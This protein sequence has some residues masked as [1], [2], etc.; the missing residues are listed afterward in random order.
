MVMK[1]FFE[2]QTI[3]FSSAT[4]METE[5]VELSEALGRILAGTVLA[6]ADMP[7]FNRSAMD[8]YACHAR[9]IRTWSSR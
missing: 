1:T 6:D 4:S 8:G 3:V 7:P 2:A 5:R 9:V